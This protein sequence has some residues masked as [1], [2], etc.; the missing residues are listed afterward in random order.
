MKK[1]KKLNPIRVARF[2]AIL[3]AMIGLFFGVVYSFGGLAIDS[4]VSL[5]WIT[6]SETPGLSMGTVLA[7][8]SLIGMPIIFTVIG[9]IL[10]MIGALL[11]NIVSPL[12]RGINLDVY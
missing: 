7:F 4:L 3:F 8:G 2:H 12:F 5:G 9:Y 6:S 1:I 11:F 10:G